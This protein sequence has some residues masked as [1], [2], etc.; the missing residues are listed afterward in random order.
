MILHRLD[1]LFRFSKSGH[2]EAKTDFKMN[3]LCTSVL[4]RLC[5]NSVMIFAQFNFGPNFFA[6]RVVVK[7]IAIGA[8]VW[9]R[10]LGQLNWTQWR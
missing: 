2:V 10:F 6:S 5:E 7:D 1:L 4:A 3:Y 8:E 9:I